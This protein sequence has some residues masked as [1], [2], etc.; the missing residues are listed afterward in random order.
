MNSN[1]T[2]EFNSDIWK[3]IMTYTAP[4]IESV[5]DKWGID[6][7]HNLY[8]KTH[9]RRFT[10]MK[11]SSIPLQERRNVLL[12]PLMRFHFK[13]D[14][15]NYIEPIKNTMELS[16]GDKV[17]WS[18]SR[19]ALYEGGIIVKVNKNSYTVQFYESRKTPDFHYTWE[20]RIPTF[21][22]VV[23]NVIKVNDYMLEEY[24]RG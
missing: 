5:L 14:L 20:D 13:H 12:T 7:L 9:R 6:K 23:G 21:K 16:V 22:K 19:W 17:N 4:Q 1:K 24:W 3:E 11:A 18:K 8:K 2:Y 15:Y 10:N